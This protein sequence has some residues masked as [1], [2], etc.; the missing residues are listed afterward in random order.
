M[1]TKYS[2]Y[3]GLITALIIA[4]LILATAIFEKLEN[5]KK[6]ISRLHGYHNNVI[7]RQKEDISILFNRLNYLESKQQSMTETVD[8]LDWLS[9]HRY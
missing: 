8:R 2:F 5:Y 9:K 3:A 6:E 7:Q 4:G 1:K